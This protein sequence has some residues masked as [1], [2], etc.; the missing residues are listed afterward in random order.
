MDVITKRQ[1]AQLWACHDMLKRL[2]PQPPVKAVEPMDNFYMGRLAEARDNA[3]K[4]LFEVLNVAD[5]YLDD[6]AAKEVLQR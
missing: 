1:A 6:P 5:A 3:I 2:G 4:A